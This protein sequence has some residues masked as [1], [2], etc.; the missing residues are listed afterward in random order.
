MKFMKD[1]HKAIL[2]VDDDQELCEE[3]ADALTYEGYRVQTAFT[4]WRACV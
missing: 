4:A 1:T 2:V 3:I